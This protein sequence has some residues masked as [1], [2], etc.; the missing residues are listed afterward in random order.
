MKRK[1]IMP[2]LREESED[3]LEEEED[4]VSDEGQEEFLSL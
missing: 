2:E 4:V 3:E 1:K